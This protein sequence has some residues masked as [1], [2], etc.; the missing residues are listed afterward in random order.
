MLFLSTKAGFL[1]QSDA[2]GLLQSRAIDAGDV[3]DGQHCL[4]PACLDLSLK[5]SLQR[6]HVNTVCSPC[7]ILCM[8]H[9]H[10]LHAQPVHM[11]SVHAAVPWGCN[12]CMHGAELELRAQPSKCSC[13]H[14]QM[15]WKLAFDALRA[16]GTW[17]HA[18]QAHVC[19][20]CTPVAA[21][22]VVQCLHKNRP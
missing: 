17:H 2:E 13:Q 9:L 12:G 6:M 3:V 1:S 4:H 5:R 21:G 20:T 14:M 19:I 18:L 7:P 8:V 11:P 10:H 16:C 22:F 15:A